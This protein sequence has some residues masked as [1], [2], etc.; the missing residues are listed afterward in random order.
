MPAD[1]SSDRDRMLVPKTAV[2]ELLGCRYPIVLAGMGGVARGELVAAVTHAGGFG[3]L[4]MVREPASLIREEVVALRNQ[5]IERF[6][7]N[8]IPAATEPGLLGEQIDTIVGLRVPVVA[9]FW[10]IDREVVT[11]LRREGLVVVYQVGSAAEAIAA[12]DA[13]ADVI[14]AQGREAG[15]HVRGTA[16]LRELLPAVA[17][18]VEVPVLAAGGLISGDDLLVS[19]ALGADGIVIGTGFL[20]TTESFAH[21]YHKQRLLAANAND[22]VLT[23]SF[24]INWPPGA[25]TRVLATPMALEGAAQVER[26]DEQPIAYEGSRPVFRFST[27]SPLRTTKGDFA[28]MALYSGTGVGKITRLRAASQVIDDL[29]DRID[30]LTRFEVNIPAEVSSPTCIAGELTGPYMGHLTSS[31]TAHEFRAIVEILSHA[32]SVVLQ[33]GL[34]SPIN[35]PP[36]NHNAI[37]WARWI[38]IMKPFVCEDAPTA[39]D[40]ASSASSHRILLLNRAR[41]AVS[42]L[43]EGIE[44][45]VLAA[46]I[47]EQVRQLA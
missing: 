36:Y 29:V 8:L 7:V 23:R 30:A 37:E 13:G 11:R 16:P 33:Q 47:Q 27:D 19:M 45:Q 25:T 44:R 31:E 14:I 15:G 2:C 22:T 38:V 6:G 46:F 39:A 26:P 3:F 24:H 18:S 32:L 5:G 20:A 21:Q 35:G 34:S 10:D 43:P 41:T 9:L 42:R 1:E 12:V 28:S 40:Q 4:G 17:A